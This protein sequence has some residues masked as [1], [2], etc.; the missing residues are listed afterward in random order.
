V[1]DLPIEA[2]I[3]D[4]GGVISSP[5]FRGIGR[6][7]A[8]MGYPEGSVLELIFGDRSLS[9]APARAPADGKAAASAGEGGYTGGEG[10][11]DPCDGAVPESASAVTHDWHRLETGEI[12]LEEYFNGVMARAPTVLG[13]PIDLDAY[14]QFTRDMPLGIH[15]P[16]VHRIRR[17]RDVGLKVGLLTNNVKEF[18]SAWRATLPV[19]ELFDTVVDSSE[20]GMR[21]PDRRIYLLTCDRLGV[22]PSLAV[23]VDDNRDNVDAARAV[24]ME[25]VHFGDEPLPAIKELDEILQRRGTRP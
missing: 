19:D 16:V 11:G 21:K 4:Y 12:G 3:W 22:D 6:F 2:V 17:L 23:F 14:R 24:G 15:W 5:L 20:V 13:R 25:A 9:Q 8:D 18:G 10:G 1:A 7:E